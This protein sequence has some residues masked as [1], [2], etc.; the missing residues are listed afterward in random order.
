MGFTDRG[1][2]NGQVGRSLQM[3]S[4]EKKMKK[5][6]DKRVGLQGDTG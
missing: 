3:Q 4:V 1:G 2:P 6:I 5:E